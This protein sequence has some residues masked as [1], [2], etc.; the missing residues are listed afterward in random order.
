MDTSTIV[1]TV[2]PT[3]EP[4]LKIPEFVYSQAGMVVIGCAVVVLLMMMVRRP[5]YWDGGHLVNFLNFVI[6][7][8]FHNH[9]NTGYLFNITFITARCH[10]SLDACQI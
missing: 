8:I 1:P 4:I 9:Q 7:S 5:K 6:F 3:D 10:R 2:P